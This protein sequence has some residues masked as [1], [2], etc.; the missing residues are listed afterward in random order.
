M[1]TNTIINKKW[2][3]EFS[4]LPQNYSMKEVENFIKLAEVIWLEPC[5]GT[6]FYDE[7]LE[8]VANNQVTSANSTA[9]VEA[10]YPYLAIAVNYESLPSLWAQL[11]EV[12]VVKGK[13]DNSDSISLK[14][15]TYYEQFIRRQLE[16]RKDYCIKWL[17][18]HQDSFPLFDTSKCKCGCND[19]CCNN[20]PQLNM[21]NP[22]LGLFKT[23]VKCTDLK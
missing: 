19:T 10:I 14:E 2:L 20:S 15:M 22:N 11:S 1:I 4:L 18:Q 3:Q 16:A 6:P 8:Q 13:S 17:C 12:G 21:P 9:L 5:I 23:N 7:L